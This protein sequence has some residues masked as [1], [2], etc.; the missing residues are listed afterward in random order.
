[1]ATIEDAKALRE[2]ALARIKE[3]DVIDI[4]DEE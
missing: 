1:V 4:Q 3:A 2:K